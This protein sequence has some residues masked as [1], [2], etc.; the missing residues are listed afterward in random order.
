ML[1]LP[2]KLLRVRLLPVA[3]KPR[4]IQDWLS[5]FGHFIFIWPNLMLLNK[6]MK[7]KYYLKAQKG[8]TGKCLDLQ[9]SDR[10]NVDGQMDVT[11]ARQQLVYI[12]CIVYY[13]IL[14]SAYIIRHDR[15][16]AYIH[17]F[18]APC[19]GVTQPPDRTNKTNFWPIVLCRGVSKAFKS[20]F[21]SS[22]VKTSGVTRPWFNGILSLCLMLGLIYVWPS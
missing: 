20:Y 19:I 1:H 12:H 11:A 16:A 9:K 21:N 13:T 10:Q 8:R 18:I 5:F 17:F 14:Y 7:L 2:V 4:I 3:H 15:R 6:P 22:V